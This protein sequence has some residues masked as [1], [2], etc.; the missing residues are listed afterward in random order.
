MESLQQSGS[1]YL[2]GVNY[3]NRF[4]PEPW[5]ARDEDS[6]Y[7][8]KYGPEVKKPDNVGDLSF[9]DVTDDRIIRYLDDMVKEEHFRMMQSWGVKVVRLPA[10]Y[11]NWLDLG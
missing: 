6:I 4:I 1:S 3:G 8:T 5:M 2:E 11:W 10:G 7:K 9:C